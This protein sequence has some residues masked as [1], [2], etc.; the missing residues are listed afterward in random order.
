M[1]ITEKEHKKNK[2]M[3]SDNKSTSKS[4]TNVSDVP[5]WFDS[6]VS[7]SISTEESNELDKLLEDLV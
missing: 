2:K 5:I 4:N 3:F 1:N 7:A 6:K